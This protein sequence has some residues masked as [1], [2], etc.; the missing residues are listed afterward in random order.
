MPTSPCG[1]AAPLSRSAMR[2]STPGRGKPTGKADG[3]GAPRAVVGV[4]GVHVGLGH[5]VA[6]QDGMA[7][8]GLEGL[9][10][11]GGE[12]G[13]ARDEEAHVGNQAPVEVRSAQEPGVEGRYAHHGRRLGQQAKDLVQVE[14]G[15]QDHRGARQQGHVGGDE[16]AVGV[17]DR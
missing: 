4:R 7:G 3:A 16:E 15:Q 2:S 5:A 6:F 12:G 10:G 13:R 1:S 11:L 9:V 8:A 17:E 14:A